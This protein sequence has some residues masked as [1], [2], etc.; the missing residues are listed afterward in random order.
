M[1]NNVWKNIAAHQYETFNHFLRFGLSNIMANEQS[2]EVP[3]TAQSDTSDASS[4]SASFHNIHVPRPRLLQEDMQY[5]Y[6]HPQACRERDLSYDAPVLVDIHEIFRDQHGVETQHIYR[7]ISVGNIPIM[8]GSSCCNLCHSR[9]TPKERVLRG[10]CD[11]DPGGYFIIRGKER[12]LVGQIRAGYNAPLVLEQKPNDKWSLVTEMRS[13]SEETCH[14]VLVQVKLQRN[15]DII[16]IVNNRGIIGVTTLN[17]LIPYI[18]SVN[19]FYLLSSLI[20]DK[21]AIV[22]L[23]RRNPDVHAFV[24]GEVYKGGAE[25]DAVATKADALALIAKSTRKDERV[26]PTDLVRDIIR[27]DMFPHLGMSATELEIAELVVYMVEE[28]VKCHLGISTPS[29]R[30]DYKVK[31]VEMA[32]TLC[33]ELFR[34]LFKRFTKSLILQIEKKKHKPDIVP[35]INRNTVIS[36]GFRHCFATGKWG[37]QK[38]AYIRTGVSQVLSRLSY[39]SMIS[40]LRRVNIPIAAESKNIKIRLIHPSQMMYMCP[41]ESPEGVTCGI[42]MNLALMTKVS[43]HIPAVLVRGFVQSFPD[44][45]FQC[46]RTGSRGGAPSPRVFIN[47]RIVGYTNVP[48]T[49]VDAFRH[50]KRHQMMHYSTSVFCDDNGDVKILSDEGRLIRPLRPVDRETGAVAPATEVVYLDNSEVEHTSHIAF[51]P[52]DV[53]PHLTDYLEPDPCAIMGVT[54]NMIPFSDHTQAPRNVYMSAMAKQA[55]SFPCSNFHSRTDAVSYLL[56]YPQ[57]PLVMTEVGHKLGYAEMPAGIN[58]IV[59]VAC[60]EGYNQ[61]DGIVINKSAVDRGL[62]VCAMY[63]TITD[64]EK[65]RGPNNVS[66]SSMVTAS[67]VAAAAA[68][69]AATRVDAAAVTAVTAVTAV[70]AATAAA[71]ATATATHGG[72]GGS[73][74]SSF[75]GNGV[76]HICVPAFSVRKQDFNYS[77]LDPQTGIIRKGA[78]CNRGDVIIGKVITRKRQKTDAMRNTIEWETI[79]ISVV[80]RGN[81]VEGVVDRVFRGKTANGYTVVKIVIRKNKIPELGDKVCS[82]FA[83]KST[84][85][86]VAAQ[87]DLPFTRE[88]ICPDLIINPHAFPSRMTINQLMATVLGKKC[89]LAGE[90]F[91][92]GTPFSETSGNIEKVCDELRA[93]GF[94]GDGLETMTN[95]MTGERIPSRIFIGPTYYFRLKHLSSEKLHARARGSVTNLYRQ[96]LEGRSRGGGLRIGEMEASSLLSSGISKMTRE[97]LFE[98]SDYYQLPMCNGCGDFAHAVPELE[99]VVGVAAAAASSSS[100][101][102]QTYY[103][104][105]CKTTETCGQMLLPYA[106]KLLF[107]QLNTMGIKTKMRSGY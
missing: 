43:V 87:E 85:G 91:G 48:S 66:T 3:I 84:I 101:A 60:F 97:R 6:L 41:S 34:T 50:A 75:A 10:E 26:R 29:D 59:A 7:S 2:I 52:S 47:G 13:I 38:T 63:H 27:S 99:S 81:E 88:G 73:G 35:M 54:T 64:E 49:F 92:D 39:G 45:V 40:H 32:G 36:N 16:K 72:S 77:K 82:N 79:D 53:I 105:V 14:S 18:G 100:M 107:F 33:H 1:D 15:D 24:I 61:E 11:M 96:P 70:A 56:S 98:F 89:L 31:R 22:D 12:V 90:R 80:T 46:I 20:E 4:Y 69:V 51:K 65:R 102:S 93:L 83:Q 21:A 104:R 55:I 95:G 106:A 57:K 17:I 68:V 58:V 42:V 71:T 76:E 74:A 19:V 67:H 23:F 62:F 9:T 78:F 5:Q 44:D 86:R 37:V 28:T 30:D 25:Y 8:I 94:S 103:C